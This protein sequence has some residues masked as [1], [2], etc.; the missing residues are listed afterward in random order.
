M[1]IIDK[2]QPF[3]LPGL[4]YGI[5]AIGLAITFRFL[6]FPD[7]TVLGSIMVG[8]IVCIYISNFSNTTLGL[9]AGFISGSILGLFTGFIISGLKSSI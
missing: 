8:G 6:K 1:E 3:M 7:F 9:I 2:L 5:G 4:I